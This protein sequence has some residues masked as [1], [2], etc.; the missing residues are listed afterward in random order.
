MT[1]RIPRGW[2]LPFALLGG[3]AGWY[4]LGRGFGK[5]MGWW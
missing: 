3:I 5:W 2:W 1:V 4:A